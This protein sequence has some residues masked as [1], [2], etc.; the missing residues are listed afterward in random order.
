MLLLAQLRTV[1]LKLLLHLL[2]S[3]FLQ[4]V[5][6]VLQVML[7][8]TLK[9]LDVLLGYHICCVDGPGYA[10][11]LNSALT[12]SCHVLGE[13]NHWCW[14]LIHSALHGKQSCGFG[15]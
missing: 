12:L 14:P 13:I 2:L 11:S 3:V 10:L 1:V 4:D 15:I 5:C 8:L 7:D 6:Y 9:L